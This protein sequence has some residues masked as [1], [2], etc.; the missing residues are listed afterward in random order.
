MQEAT[1]IR[2]EDSGYTSGRAKTG[3]KELGFGRQTVFSFWKPLKCHSQVLGCLS[4]RPTYNSISIEVEASIEKEIASLSYPSVL[5][6]T[7]KRS[8]WYRWYPCSTVSSSQ[9]SPEIRGA[10]SYNNRS[11]GIRHTT[12]SLTL[13][14]ISISPFSGI[15]YH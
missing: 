5:E 13:H 2:A 3:S 6:L 1:C 9:R 15:A 8:G 7:L 11:Q 12:R 4:L 10:F 14:F